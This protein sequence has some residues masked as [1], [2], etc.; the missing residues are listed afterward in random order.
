[1]FGDRFKVG[2]VEAFKVSFKVLTLNVIYPTKFD[3]KSLRIFYVKNAFIRVMS[4]TLF[5]VLALFHLVKIKRENIQEV[6]ISEDAV[7]IS[8]GIGTVLVMIF[9]SLKWRGWTRFLFQLMDFTEFGRPAEIEDCI[10]YLRFFRTVGYAVSSWMEAPNCNRINEE[11]DYHLICDTFV[12]IWLPFDVPNKR[13]RQVI[14]VLQFLLINTAV[15]SAAIVCFLTWECTEIL[16]VHIHH[17]V[18]HFRKVIVKKDVRTRPDGMASTIQHLEKSCTGHLL[19]ISAIVIGC[20]EYQLLTTRD[21]APALYCS[22]W[23]L[24]DPKVVRDMVLL[25]KRAQKPVSLAALPLGD[26][27]YALFLM[28]HLR[29][30]KVGKEIPFKIT[31]KILMLNKLFPKRFDDKA[32]LKRFH[33][34]SVTLRILAFAFFCVGSSLHL[35]KITKGTLGYGA[36]ALMDAPFCNRINEEKNYHLICDTFVSI[37]LPF[38]ITYRPYRWLIFAAQFFLVNTSVSSAAMVCFLVWESSRILGAHLHHLESHFRKLMQGGN[39]DRSRGIG[40]WIR[41]HNHIL[42]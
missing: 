7:V 28:G 31:M 33:R 17:L 4:F 15:S 37:W 19:L 2:S 22:D 30:F 9:F 38:D 14:F 11:H 8:G 16:A 35:M 13:H 39:M 6:E 5:S 40:Y 29:M 21:A 18:D 12:P 1:M 10:K 26:A 34:E 27:D 20:S 24:A 42:E 3:K 41:Y 23:Y 32:F 36:A 25:L